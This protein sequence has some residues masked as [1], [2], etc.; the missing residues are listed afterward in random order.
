MISDL[1]RKFIH[2]QKNHKLISV[3]RT[4]ILTQVYAKTANRDTKK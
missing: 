2:F 4:T 1:M 3:Y